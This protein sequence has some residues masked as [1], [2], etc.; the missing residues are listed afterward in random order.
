MNPAEQQRIMTSRK[1]FKAASW[2]TMPRWIKQALTASGIDMI[3]YSDG[4]TRAASTSKA[5]A[6]GASVDD[7]M[8][9]GGWSHA[10]TFTMWYKIPFA[11]G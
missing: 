3:A 2:D 5:L 9:F 6:G 11:M 10:S 1:P 8:K 4:S 7:I